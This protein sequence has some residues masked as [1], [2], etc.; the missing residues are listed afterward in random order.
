MVFS[1]P[2]FLLAL[3]PV[4]AVAAWVLYRPGRELAVV[5]T[6]SLWRQALDA[7]DRTVRRRARRVTVAWVLLLAGAVAA[8]LAGAGPLLRRAAPSRRVAVS[9][10]PSAELGRQGGEAVRLAAGKLLDRLSANDR[11]QVVLPTL[12]GG[13]T[14]WLSPEQAQARLAELQAVPVPT[15]ELTLPEADAGAQHV[16]RIVPA[17]SDFAVGP[18]V[19]NIELPTA[20]GEV[21]IEAVGA[22]LLPDGRVRVLAALGNR[23]GAD[24]RVSV[25]LATGDGAG[26]ALSP[27]AR[28]NVAMPVGGGARVI[29]TVDDAPAISVSVINGEGSPVGAEAYLVRREAAVRSVALVGRDE[30]LLRRFIGS[31][32]GLRLVGDA[33]QADVVVANGADPPPG[34][35]ALVVDPPTSPPGWRRG[36]P[37]EAVLLDGV[38]VADVEVMRHVD[39]AGTA[40]RYVRSWVRAGAGGGRALAWDENGALILRARGSDMDRIY[41]AFD[42]AESNTNF[43]TKNEFVYLLANVIDA[44]APGKARAAFGYETPLQATPDRDWRSLAG[45]GPLPAGAF[46][47]PGLY[48]DAG[49][50]PHA[51]SLVGLRPAGPPAPWEQAIADVPLPAPEYARRGVSLWPYLAVAACGLWLAGWVVRL[52]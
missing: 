35:P 1:S 19:T 15:A 29:E 14:G 12:L 4:A 49:G 46:A 45:G 36:E 47:W 18:N 9:I 32:E 37:R 40:V 13:A 20:V 43:A 3:L 7:L 31:H 52:R 16:Y 24:R 10:C 50:E 34:K 44:L 25:L 41:V 51:V 8:V 42:L 22:E 6:L 48:V 27:R 30:P 26:G 5:A 38:T 28:A 2:W 21:T 33:E 23:S 11:V 39:F 17:G